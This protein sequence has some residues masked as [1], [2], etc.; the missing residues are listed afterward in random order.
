MHCNL[1]KIYS[2]TSTELKCGIIVHKNFNRQEK[3]LN[4]IECLIFKHSMFLPFITC[5]HLVVPSLYTFIQVENR[6]KNF[7]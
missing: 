4:G 6:R 7:I 3:K 2:K 1:T 5:A